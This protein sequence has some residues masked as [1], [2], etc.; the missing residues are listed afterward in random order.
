MKAFDFQY[1]VIAFYTIVVNSCFCGNPVNNSNSYVN[2]LDEISKDMEVTNFFSRVDLPFIPPL[3]VPSFPGPVKDF[4]K[5]GLTFYLDN[6]LFGG[7]DEN[8]TNGARLS[9]ISKNRELNTIP[10]VQRSLSQFSGLGATGELFYNYGFSLTQL[11]FTPVD[12]EANRGPESERPYAGWLG[13]GMSLHAKNEKVL[14]SIELSIGV[15]GPSSLAEN[16][17]DFIHDLRQIEKAN[18]WDSQL[19]NELTVNFHFIQ[20]IKFKEFP[21]VNEFLKWQSLMFWGVDIGNLKTAGHVGGQIRLGYN[22]PDGLSAGKLDVTAY[23]HSFH[24]KSA[25]S[26]K[27]SLFLFAEAEAEL[28]LHNVFLDGPLFNSSR[29]VDREPLV[30]EVSFGGGIGY[31]N[32]TIQYSHTYRTSEYESQDDDQFFGSLSLTILF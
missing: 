17:Q 3:L 30:S 13:V 1:L 10:A 4:R 12:I 26:K 19:P 15:V 7:T 16:T 21:M 22:L 28:V 25:V 2:N 11:M 24:H 20:K 27:V 31:K 6:D 9:W 8:Y 29:S 23:Q 32:Y 5:G 14:N 18:G